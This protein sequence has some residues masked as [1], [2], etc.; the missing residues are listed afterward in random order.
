[1]GSRRMGRLKKWIK[2]SAMYIPRALKFIIEGPPIW[3][4]LDFK[5]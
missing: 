2:E 3:V 5:V 4:S 1:M